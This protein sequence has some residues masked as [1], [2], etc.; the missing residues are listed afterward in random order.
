MLIHKPT[1]K[2]VLRLRE[3]GRVTT[4]IP[5]ARTFDHQGVE[6]LA[7]PHRI[8]ET[9][10]LRNL[11]FDVPSPIREHYSWPGLFKPFHAQLETA[12]FLTMNPRA[13][14]NNSMGCVDADTEYLSPSG[15]VRIADYIGGEVAQYHPDTGAIDFVAPEKF[16]KLPCPEML[17]IKTKYGLDQL[18][19]PE[20][21]V[22][23][24]SKVNPLKR[25]VVQASELYGRQMAWLRGERS[26]WSTTTMSWT[27][28]AI[29]VTFSAP[30]GEG[31]PLSDEQ[32]RVQIAVI[33]DGY[34]A[35]RNLRCVVRLKKQRKVERL[36][37]LLTAANIPHTQRHQ[38][39][40]GYEIF[41]FH[42]PRHDK[43]FS[44][45][46]WRATIDQLRIVVDEV[47]RWDGSVSPNKP[48]SRFSSRS[49]AS[50][51]FVQYAFAGCGKVARV[52]R[53]TRNRRGEEEVDHTVQVR[54]T[55]GPLMMMSV[56]SDGE[57]R[58]TMWLE[59]STDGF[60]YCFVVPTSFLLFRRNGCIFASGNTGKT[61]SALWA[62]DYLR[63]VGKVHRALVVSPL[64]TLERTWAD[65]VFR[66]FPHLTT[67]TLHGPKK[68]REKMLDLDA[69][70]YLINHDGVVTMGEQLAKREDIDLII[71]D[72]IATFRNASTHRWKAL[73][74]IAKTRQYVWGLTGTPTPNGPMDAWAQIRL[75]APER[76]PPYMTAWRDQV[77]RQVGPFQWLPREGATQ[78]V[79][80]AMRPAIRFS[81]EDCVDLPPCVAMDR[82]AQ[83]TP[84]QQRHYKD[85]LQKLKVEASQQQIVAVNEAVKLGKLVQIACGAVYSNTGEV[86]RIEAPRRVEV[87]EEVIEQA[88][89]KT[90]VY[91]PYR[92]VLDYV[93]EALRARKHDVATIDGGTPKGERD[94]IFAAF[95]TSTQY[96]VLVAQPAAMSHGLT[97][98][99]ASAIV[100][101]APVTSHETY[102]QAN[103]RVSRPGQKHTQ[104]LVRVSGS[105]VER[106]LYDRLEKRHT[107]QGALLDILREV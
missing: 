99:A 55:G 61:L 97:L 47:M 25:E 31:I 84:E 59:P 63:E 92:G 102:A 28:A 74:R 20:H 71:V 18:L 66:H 94:R 36:K 76:V 53:A 93:A 16:V 87:V 96:D 52:G 65:E 29:P 70:V 34:F 101:W 13:F 69:D 54:D 82:D 21:R 86:V 41:T 26:T 103:A 12:D 44:P 49:K 19:S 17:R 60:K 106:R 91:V 24:Q 35:G 10:V 78:L 67:A 14:C 98:T 15:W 73:N 77:L 7:V 56:A 85:M 89:A 64:S 104:L 75:V 48:G 6:L 72:E 88:A 95:Q 33:A 62:F 9:K 105:P 80:E 100:W 83:M 2:V 81:L 11:G 50:S 46:Y 4:V 39:I 5:T 37:H 107:M 32:L 40:T 22:L 23:L 79:A 43:E 38:A 68:R 58:Q 30:S 3:P 8:D 51:D 90:I 45:I 1:Q 42:A 27:Q 57:K